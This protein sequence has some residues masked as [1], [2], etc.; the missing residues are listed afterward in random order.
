MPKASSRIAGLRVLV[1]DD[2]LLVALHIETLLEDLGC[3]VIGPV[4][5]IDK[6][7][8][9]MRDEHL[10][11]VLLDANLDGY[12]SAP[13]AA[14]LRSRGVPF[15]VVTGY[16]QLELASPALTD[17]PRLSKPFN[18]TE[19]EATLTAAFCVDRRASTAIGQ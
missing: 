4:P 13:V 11:G 9:V 16:G 10:D 17:A 18:D 19:F 8:A 3:E 12:S 15:V 7:L 5:T 1:V 6:A 2:E 14:E